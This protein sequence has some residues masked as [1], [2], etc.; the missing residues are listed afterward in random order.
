MIVSLER[1]EPESCKCDLLQQ[2]FRVRNVCQIAVKVSSDQ[3]NRVFFFI[4]FLHPR[5]AA[6]GRAAW[7]NIEDASDSVIVIME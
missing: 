6:T 4:A 3:S 7:K 2:H 1:V 5:V